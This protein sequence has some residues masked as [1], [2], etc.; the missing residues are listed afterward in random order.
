MPLEYRRCNN[1][2]GGGDWTQCNRVYAVEP[3]TGTFTRSHYLC[4][5][6]REPGEAAYRDEQAKLAEEYQRQQAQQP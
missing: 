1:F 2:R 5:R 6:C 3:G 4:D